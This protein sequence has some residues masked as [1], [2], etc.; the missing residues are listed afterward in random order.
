MKAVRKAVLPVAGLGTRFLPATKAV[1]K[2]MLPLVDKPLIEYA[3]DEARAVGIEE[4]IVVTGR[5]KPAIRAHFESDPPLEASL[6]E[7]GKDDLLAAVAPPSDAFSF[8]EQPGPYGLGHAVWW[9][10]YLVGDEPFAILL[11]DDVI[12][13][14]SPCLAELLEVYEEHGGNVIALTEVEPEAAHLYGIVEAAHDNGTHVEVSNI[15]EKPAPGTAPSNLGIVGRYILQPG[16]MDHLERDSRI[17]GEEI[18]LTD[19]IV[20]NGGENSTRGVRI[21]GRRFDCGTKIGYLEATVAFSLERK[22]L[23]D[24]RAAITAL[25][26]A[27]EE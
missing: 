23:G 10:R 17:P 4:F 1:P 22:D 21:S 27:G 25:L 15:V 12:M 3:I 24:V 18:Q 7:A 2:E 5:N 14:N 8:V 20:A 26:D 19:A 11:P 16:V 6:R 9:A 13:G